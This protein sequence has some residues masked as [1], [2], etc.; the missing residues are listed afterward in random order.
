MTTFFFILG[1]EIKREMIVG[2]IADI[3]RASLPIIS[4]IG[5]MIF[6]TLLY[7]LFNPPGTIGFTGW[8]IPIATDIAIA[9]GLFSVISEK[10]PKSLKIILTTRAIIDDLTTVVILSIFFVGG[11]HR[12][13]LPIGG[14][15]IVILLVF[16]RIG[17]RNYLFYLLPGMGL[18]FAFLTA[19]INATMA[20]VL[21]ALMIPATTRINIAEFC[22]LSE[23]TMDRLSDAKEYIHGVPAYQEY[24]SAVGVLRRACEDV[25]APLQTLEEKVTPWVVFG[26]IP[27]FALANVGVRLWNLSDIL[28]NSVTLGTVFGLV[29]G[30]PFGL[31]LFSFLAVKTK[32]TDLPQG[33]TWPQIIG[34]SILGGVSFTIPIFIS[35]LVFGRGM[36][37]TATKIGTLIATLI[38]GL[39]GITVLY[40]SGKSLPQ[41]E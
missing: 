14:G 16:N 9:L 10:F 36:L 8:S 35:S 4:S 26:I 3:R 21:V 41:G 11:L 31:I 2:E 6:P 40:F 5:G 19:G 12:V 24:Q 15:F 39:V 18:W 17:L 22:R 28:L 33:V 25:E 38:S 32:L 37:L 30:K 1:L 27:L 13:F 7:I 29:I 34:V 20:G 23:T